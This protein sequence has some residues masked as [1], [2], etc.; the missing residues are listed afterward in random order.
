MPIMK[1]TKSHSD[2][3]NILRKKLSAKYPWC[4]FAFYE[5]INPNLKKLRK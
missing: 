5:P 4:L 3:K 1:I 2:I